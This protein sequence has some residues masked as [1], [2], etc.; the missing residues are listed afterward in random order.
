MLIALLASLPFFAASYAAFFAFD[1]PDRTLG[2]LL[3][4]SGAVWG[5]IWVVLDTREIRKGTSPRCRH[6]P[7]SQRR[8]TS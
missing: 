5:V 2:G 6:L 8:P 3:I 7:S 1:L 4:F